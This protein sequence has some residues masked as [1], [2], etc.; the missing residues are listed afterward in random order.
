MGNMLGYDNPEQATDPTIRLYVEGITDREILLDRWLAKSRDLRTSFPEVLAVAKDQ[1][2]T[3]R[4]HGAE[5]GGCKQVLKRVEEDLEDRAVLAMGLLDRDVL[6]SQDHI[7][8]FLEADDQAFAERVVEVFDTRL[9]ERIWVLPRWELENYLLLDLDKMWEVYRDNMRKGDAHGAPTGRGE[10][11]EAFLSLA[12]ES[13]PLVARSLLLTKRGRG[14]RSTPAL[15][16]ASGRDE[17]RERVVADL[18]QSL[19][20]KAEVV[21]T[22]LDR[23][24]SRL[25]A[26]ATSDVDRAEHRWERLSRVVDGKWMLHRISS[27]WIALNVAQLRLNSASRIGDEHDG[28][29]PQIKKILSQIVAKGKSL[30]TRGVAPG[31]RNSGTS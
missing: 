27:R 14:I 12:A 19:G 23:W 13:L 7:E 18:V 22:E 31:G 20:E 26:F 2:N 8:F 17:M 25:Q 1:S 15:G 6:L 4:L 30:A 11:A 5:G 16:G 3:A 10:V 9:R 28:P 29:P 21:G 24:E